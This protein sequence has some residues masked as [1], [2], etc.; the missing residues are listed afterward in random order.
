M[1]KLVSVKALP[2]YKLFLKYEDGI[3]GELDLS[4]HVGKGVFLSLKDPN[5]FCK[6]YIGEAN[7]IS[8]SDEVDICADSA[9]LTITEKSPAEIY[10]ALR[11]GKSVA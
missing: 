6:V 10:P 4:K 8:W 7:Q 9:Y 3:S 1:V 5:R 2:G 11:K